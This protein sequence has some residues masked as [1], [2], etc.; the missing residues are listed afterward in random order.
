MGNS[1]GV[2]SW[3]WSCFVGRSW[4]WSWSCGCGSSWSCFVGWSKSVGRCR[5]TVSRSSMVDWGN[6]VSWGL[7]VTWSS[8]VSYFDNITRIAISSVVFDDLGTTIGEGNTVFTSGRVAIA[9]FTCCDMYSGNII[10]CTVSVLVLSFDINWLF[11]GWG[12]V[13]FGSMVNRSVVSLSS[14]VNWGMISRSSMEDWGVVGRSSV[15]DW[16]NLVSRR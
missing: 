11:V 5:G 10:I 16:R 8:F 15:V 7:F 3:G 12:V 6:L 9:R 2:V 1:L 13:S 14:V 4:D